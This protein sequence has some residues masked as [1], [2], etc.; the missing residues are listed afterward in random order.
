MRAAGMDVANVRPLLGVLNQ[1]GMPLYGC[2]TPDGYKN[3][4]EAW[5]N[6]DALAR[7]IG[8]ATALAVGRLPVAQSVTPEETIRTMGKRRPEHS[9]PLDAQ[10]LLHTLGPS[11]HAS[12]R[13]AIADGPSAMR[14]AMVLG[15]PDFMQ[16]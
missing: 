15:S 16:H 13:E 11:I 8:F 14:A 3:T 7:R 12:T 5:L 9:A 2:Q 10:V 4:E 6:P 1:L